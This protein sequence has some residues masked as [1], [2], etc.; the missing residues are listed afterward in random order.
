MEL[1][2]PGDDCREVFIVLMRKPT[3]VGV[4]LAV[5]GVDGEGE[6]FGAVLVALLPDAADPDET[7][8]RGFGKELVDRGFRIVAFEGLAG[9]VHVVG[10]G[11][12]VAGQRA[13]VFDADEV[14]E[15]A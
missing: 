12:D 15:I 10:D 7:A 9:D 3:Q 8:T 13:V 6:V 5:S 11:N 14:H 4:E 2:I 1:S